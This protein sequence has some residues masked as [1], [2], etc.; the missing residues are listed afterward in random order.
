MII[1]KR[2]L[3]LP[4]FLLS[5][6]FCG[7]CAHTNPKKAGTNQSEWVYPGANGKLV[8]KSTQTGDRIMDFST[9]GY[10]G[11][12]VALPTVPVA[13]TVN[14]SGGADDTATIQA[15]IDEVAK[16]PLKDAFRGAVL[17]SPGI[18]ICS[19]AIAISAS[20][21]V[22][23]GSGTNETTIQMSGGRHVA[24]RAGIGGDGRRRQSDGAQNEDLPQASAALVAQ[25]SIADAYVPS[26]TKTFSV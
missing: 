10:M 14:P 17:L 1:F 7:A 3:L 18:F 13:K 22:L 8:Y 6:A 5:L 16:M 21:I 24:I 26:G 25:T 11:G 12:G 23:R 19:N 15:A 4:T 9:A 20:G 2:R